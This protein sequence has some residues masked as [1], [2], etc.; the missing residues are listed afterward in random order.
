MSLFPDELC[1]ELQD[2]KNESI[3]YLQLQ[4]LMRLY[5]RYVELSCCTDEEDAL[6][7]MI[8]DVKEL[9]IK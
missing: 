9:P 6:E 8:E 5:S 1:L 3:P 2:N 7:R 4:S